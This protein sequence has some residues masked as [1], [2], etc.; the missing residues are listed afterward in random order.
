MWTSQ[1]VGGFWWE[2]I[3]SGFVLNFTA[4]DLLSCDMPLSCHS[5]GVRMISVHTCSLLPCVEPRGA[6]W[7]QSNTKFTMHVTKD[8]NKAIGVCGCKVA[9]C[10]WNSVQVNC[11]SVWELHAS[12]PCL[13]NF[14]FSTEHGDAHLTLTVC[15]SVRFDP[16]TKATFRILM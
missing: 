6:E 9:K 7:N 5:G 11:L 13:L 8:V 1:H 2:I 10:Q 16:A 14:R 4:N 3:W 15:S 12:Q